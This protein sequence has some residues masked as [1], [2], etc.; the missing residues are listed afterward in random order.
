MAGDGN[1]GCGA[2][3]VK[4]AATELW[5]EAEFSSK[6]LKYFISISVVS[7]KENK[8]TIHIRVGNRLLIE[9]CLMCMR[10]GAKYS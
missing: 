9:S 7:Q 6:S 5:S 8:S 1:G 10:V 3:E 4:L 2:S